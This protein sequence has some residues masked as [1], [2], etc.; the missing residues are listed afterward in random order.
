ML[1][2]MEMIGQPYGLDA[3]EVAQYTLLAVEV[4]HHMNMGS[5][6]EEA[7]SLAYATA[8]II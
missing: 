1:D 6:F 8:E 5:D 3:F 4:E 7:L 2:F